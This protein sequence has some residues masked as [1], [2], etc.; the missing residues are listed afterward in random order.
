LSKYDVV[1][2]ACEGG[3]NSQYKSA[4]AVQAMFDYAA[5]GGRIF[6]S[7]WH[8]DWLKAGPEPFPQTA[9]WTIF[10]SLPRKHQYVWVGSETISAEK[11]M[12]R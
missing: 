10:G 1:L 6:A 2:L 9:V 7:H 11:V 12:S 3:Q 5:K 8:N 4:A